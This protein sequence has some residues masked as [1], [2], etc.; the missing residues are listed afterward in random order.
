MLL[1]CII[2]QVNFSL[3]SFF[4]NSPEADPTPY[5]ER[6][7]G[8]SE[9]AFVERPELYQSYRLWN[10]EGPLG[11]G[12]KNGEMLSRIETRFGVK[13]R[14]GIDVRQQKS[15]LIKNRLYLNLDVEFVWPSLE[16]PLLGEKGRCMGLSNHFGILVDGTVVPC[17]LDKEASIPLGKIQDQSILEIL[18]S[19]RANEM[20]RGFKQGKLIEELC[21]RCSFIERFKT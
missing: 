11:T 6:I 9:R 12:S 1:R 17:C 14:D 4:D 5:L 10:L 18:E 2:K 21:K 16:L 3:H 15:H 19:K 20:V 8:F 7:F 13:M